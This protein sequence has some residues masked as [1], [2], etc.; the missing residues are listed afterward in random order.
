[1]LGLINCGPRAE[2]EATKGAVTLKILVLD[3]ETSGSL[4]HIDIAYHVQSYLG[5]NSDV[6]SGI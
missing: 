6:H 2:N 5:R 4:Q 1:M 3:I